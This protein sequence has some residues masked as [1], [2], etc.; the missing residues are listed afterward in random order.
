MDFI[1]KLVREELE[2]MCGAET[3]SDNCSEES[4]SSMLHYAEENLDKSKKLEECIRLIK[5]VTELN[6]PDDFKLEKINTILFS[7]EKFGKET[8]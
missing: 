1:R 4:W 3:P 2:T 6:E 5:R 8:G 7:Y